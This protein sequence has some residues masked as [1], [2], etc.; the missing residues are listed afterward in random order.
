M[1]QNQVNWVNE[2][3]TKK[4][5]TLL[6]HLLRNIQPLPAQLF[7][8]TFKSH[9]SDRSLRQQLRS[10]IATILEIHSRMFNSFSRENIWC[11]VSR[12][13]DS[14]LL[15]EFSFLRASWHF[16]SHTYFIFLREDLS[17]ITHICRVHPISI[18]ISRGELCCRW[19]INRT[20]RQHFF[21]LRT[22]KGVI[23]DD[24]KSFRLPIISIL[25]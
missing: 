11:D 14:D 1:A 20:H 3:A 5:Q 22:P 17:I 10:R 8:D 18:S 7:L 2:D 12:S 9:E 21:F 6:K 4:R 15:K 19:K 23:C 16:C 13:D 25:L 24:G